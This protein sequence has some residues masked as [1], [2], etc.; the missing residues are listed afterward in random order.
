MKHFAVKL[1]NHNNIEPSP[2]SCL[3][4]RNG[5]FVNTTHPYPVILKHFP[6]LALSNTLLSIRLLNK[7]WSYH[8]IMESFRLAK[9]SIIKSTV[10]LALPSP[11][12]N[13][14][15]KHLIYTSSEYLQG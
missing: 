10:N 5:A 6:T 4:V 7:N 3:T 14:D 11:P 9:T 15:P 8:R 2:Y 12:L 1:P 13:P